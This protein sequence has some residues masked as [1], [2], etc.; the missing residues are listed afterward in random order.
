MPCVQKT[1][2]PL[3]FDGFRMNENSSVVPWRRG[4]IGISAMVVFGLTA[5]RVLL[6]SLPTRRG[7]QRASFLRTRYANHTG[8][9]LQVPQR[10]APSFFAA[11]RS[12][13]Q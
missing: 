12:K 11:S 13:D 2:T 5:G 1:P 3:S 6:S 7:N 10:L 4:S 9:L 8:A